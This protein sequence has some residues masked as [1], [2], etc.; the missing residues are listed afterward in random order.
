MIR[1][2][3]PAAD[4]V[5]AVFSGGLQGSGVLL[6]R[7][8]VLT[9]AHVLG[10]TEDTTVA[11]PSGGGPVPVEVVWSDP[12]ADLALLGFRSRPGV[13]PAGPPGR[14]SRL[15]LGQVATRSP[16]PD[17]EVIGF[18][19]VQRQAGDLDLDQFE[20]TVLPGAGRLRGV[21]TF[22][23]AR[24]SAA[25]PPAD[26]AA[27]PLEGLSG[28]PVF[29][30]EVL[31]GVVRQVPR[32]RNHVRLECVPVTA[33]LPT[34]PG[35][36]PPQ[37]FDDTF[38]QPEPAPRWE[39]VTASHAGD[40]AYEEEY[41]RAV[42][43]H[44]R[45]SKIFGIDGL[46]T[47]DTTW[48]MDTAY[49][50][51]EAQPPVAARGPGEGPPG[52]PGTGQPRRVDELLSDRPRTLLRGEAGAGKTTLVWWLAA[53][54]AEHTLGPEL[55]ELNGLVPFVVPL[56]E[57]RSK[58]LDFPIPSQLA[59]VAR[60]AVDDPPD[61]WAGRVLKAG[62]GLLLIDGLDEVPAAEREDARDWLAAF[63]LQHPQTRC[64]ATV[65]PGAVDNDWL[66]SEKFEE[67]TLLPMRD[68]DIRSFVAAWHRTA[69]KECAGYPDPQRARE[70]RDELRE[71][72]TDLLQ[73]F[74]RNPALQ[75][76]ARTPLLCAVICALHRRRGGMLPD[77]RW[78]LYRATLAMLLGA[79]D[80]RRKVC[81]P[82]GIAM[83]PEEHQELL[84]AIAVWLVRTGQNQLTPAEAERR[85]AQALRALPQVG[86]QGGPAT[87]LKHLLNRSGLL[88]ER[89]DDAI[90]FIHR[91]FQDYLAAKALI[92]GGGPKELLNHARDEQWQDVIQL[93]VG[94]CRPAERV[95]L[96][97]GLLDQ[98]DQAAEAEQRESLHLL[99]AHCRIGVTVLDGE[100]QRAVDDRVRSMLPPHVVSDAVPLASLGPYLLPFLP[101]PDG[102]P[103]AVAR[104]VV[105]LIGAV[106]GREAV[107]YARRFT[108]CAAAG[109]REMLCGS[110]SRYPA[111]EYATEVLAR[112]PLESE[113]LNVRTREQLSQLGVLGRVGSIALMSSAF[114]PEEL[115]RHFTSSVA[116]RRL[117]IVGNT[118]IRDLGF[119]RTQR[120]LSHLYL[121][122]CP[123]LR[124]IS[125]VA[126]HRL[127]SL[128]LDVPLALTALAPVRRIP[129]L[130][131]LDIRLRQENGEVGLP[132]AHPDV[133]RL[134]VTADHPFPL[135][136][137]TEWPALKHLELDVRF[138]PLSRLGTLAP[139]SQVSE[140]TLSLR[141]PPDFAPVEP[142]PRITS[143]Q[144]LLR[145][146]EPVGWLGEIGR[147]FPGLT[148][149]RLV[150][151]RTS[152]VTIPLDLTPLGALPDVQVRLDAHAEL[153]LIG[154]EALGDRLTVRR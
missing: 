28:A 150:V 18:P 138:E 137:L 134:K 2:P 38:R 39:E 112:M 52:S 47:N 25:E 22:E 72:E 13:A 68:T 96:I 59:K 49:L 65:R 114:R 75:T 40:Q 147:L 152:G 110:W 92:D 123:S 94:H 90:Q 11:H 131:T 76:L 80:K 16:L 12:A 89:S 23:L 83:G 7:L 104:A 144:L 143:L 41:A 64:M 81:N 46:D 106:G 93:A 99:A 117:M 15:R 51:L 145:H 54:A 122:R 3:L 78:E 9:C 4:R 48:D 153:T 45:R 30:G 53:H 98:G 44:Y 14:W 33:L 66:R 154:E 108:N 5:V 148:A 36:A 31:L 125:A 63:L 139:A 20:G 61:G 77:T 42:R 37:N 74:A 67:L 58:G 116:V 109:V 121:T 27:S 103:A 62:R 34:A 115:T 50:S 119:L 124:D 6:S 129:G 142:L 97:R 130:G 88:Q 87:V 35:Q 57:L 135:D 24:P 60:L 95:E 79:R 1:G 29:A 10:D 8:T 102:L 120:E 113:M 32:G 107:P 85:I 19:D 136:S 141:Q 71:L 149:L 105:D 140:L 69:R 70:E 26:G 128:S 127:R 126:E 73:Q 133:T 146:P 56:R 17:C 86:E 84:Q 118:R 100:V 101:G 43:N 82:E 132:E 21:L 55:A 111:A 91:T 151:P